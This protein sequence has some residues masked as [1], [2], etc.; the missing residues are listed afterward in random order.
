MY[1]FSHYQKSCPEKLCQSISH[2][3]ISMHKRTWCGHFIS[4]SIDKFCSMYFNENRIFRRYVCFYAN[5]NV[6]FCE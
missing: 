2:I 5:M 6:L 1:I 3:F 4:N